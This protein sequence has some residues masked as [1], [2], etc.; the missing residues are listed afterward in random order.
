MASA[1][2][3]DAIVIRMILLPATLQLFGDATWRIPRIL[4]RH[5]P[6]ITVEPTTTERGTPTAAE[7]TS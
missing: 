1:I 4:D 2:F 5:L 3:L 6:R 7:A